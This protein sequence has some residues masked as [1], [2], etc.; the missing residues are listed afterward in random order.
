MTLQFGQPPI[1]LMGVLS[2]GLVG[3][4]VQAPHGQ[5]RIIQEHARTG[6]Q[7]ELR[8]PNTAIVDPPMMGG[9]LPVKLP[10]AQL[11]GLFVLSIH[12]KMNIGIIL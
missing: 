10:V 4:R 3:P 6:G 9:G 1:D 12:S 5:A 2:I 7:M 8:L 11:K